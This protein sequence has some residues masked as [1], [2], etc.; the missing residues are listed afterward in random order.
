ML[1]IGNLGKVAGGVIRDCHGDWVKGYSK[2]SGYTTSVLAEWWALQDGPIL[3]IQLGINQLEVELDAKVIV[4][5]LNGVECPKSIRSSR[6][7]YYV[8][9][10]HQKPTLLFVPTVQ[11]LFSFKSQR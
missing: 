1:P 3:A 8:I 9:L 11:F 2:S 4:E 5:L 7:K 10:P 6:C